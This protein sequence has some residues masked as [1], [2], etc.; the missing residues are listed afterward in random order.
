[1]VDCDKSGLGATRVFMQGA[2]VLSQIHQKNKYVSFYRLECY[3]D[4]QPN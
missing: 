2:G 1:M 3:D 4:L